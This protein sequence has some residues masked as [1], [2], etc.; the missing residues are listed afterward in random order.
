MFENTIKNAFGNTQS[1]DYN[2]SVTVG[3]EN[4]HPVQL[5]EFPVLAKKMR[6]PGELQCER[7]NAFNN[8]TLES[9]IRTYSELKRQRISGFNLSK[10]RL[11]TES[12]GTYEIESCKSFYSINKKMD[13]FICNQR[14]KLDIE[15]TCGC[16]DEDDP[17]LLIKHG[18]IKDAYD[19]GDLVIIQPEFFAAKM[20][21]FDSDDESSTA[22]VIYHAAARKLSVEIANEIPNS[23]ASDLM[24][25]MLAYFIVKNGSEEL[26]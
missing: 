8:G 3:N 16:I 10:K 23:C 15:I 6:T 21:L 25:D 20:I 17:I 4:A 26:N 22:Y 14:E 24:F 19:D 12:N 9:K 13:S 11:K 18:S 7:A 5:T 2:A 1:P